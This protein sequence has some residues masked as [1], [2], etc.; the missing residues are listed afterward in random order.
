MKQLAL[1]L[2]LWFLAAYCPEVAAQELKER[3]TFKGRTDY[4][5]CVAL[6]P[7]G[8]TLACGGRR[9]QGGQWTLW[10]VASGK[11]IT[12]VELSQDNVEALA[13]SA[14]GRLLAS[15]GHGGVS[16][17]EM[18]AGKQ[19]IA[20][21]GNLDSTNTL[22]FSADGAKVA[23][24]GGRL[25]RLWD[26]A[27]GKELS[28]FTRLISGSG[29]PAM[30]FSN[31]LRTLASPNYEEIDLWDVGAGKQRAILS[32]HRGAVCCATFSADSKTLVAASTLSQGRST[33]RGEVRLWDMATG[34]ERAVW[35]EHIGH[36]R[37]VRLSPDGKTLAVLDRQDLYDEPDL[38]LIEVTTGRQLVLGSQPTAFFRF[39]AFTTDGRLFVTGTRDNKTQ[40][41][42]EVVLPKGQGK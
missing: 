19:R 12:T 22:A 29:W 39:L 42:W 7:D 21:R 40:K 5:T 41:L 6:S 23:A 8:Q 9:P 30:A 11:E 3:G 15:A 34:R 33:Y 24:A 16:V 38:K 28:T 2:S 31:D 36:V 32:E 18:P 10:D 26:V 4:V 35:Q 37:A 17:W 27:S 1:V 25:V 14:D 13:F 20:L